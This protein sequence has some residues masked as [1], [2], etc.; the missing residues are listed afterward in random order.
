MD[1]KNKKVK[2]INTEDDPW[3]KHLNALW[4]TP[5]E[6]CQPYTEDNLVQINLADDVNP[7][8]TF[9]SKTMPLGEKEGLISLEREYINVFAWSS[10]WLD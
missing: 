8:P 3:I 7:K 9:F 6:Q 5:F 4:D 10:T 2:L 1:P